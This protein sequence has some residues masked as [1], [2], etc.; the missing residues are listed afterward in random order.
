[1]IKVCFRPDELYL[2]VPDWCIR[3]NRAYEG[4]EAIEGVEGVTLLRS[5]DW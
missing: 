5:H 2:A 1:L 4:V 3:E